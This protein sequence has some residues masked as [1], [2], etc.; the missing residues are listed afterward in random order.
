MGVITMRMI[1]S[2]S[3]T[4][5]SGVTLIAELTGATLTLCTH[6]LVLLQEEVEKFGRGVRHLDLEPLEPRR[7]IVERHD[8][9]NGDQDAERGRD[10]RLGDTGRHGRETARSRRRDAGERVDDPDDRAEQADE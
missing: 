5:T 4:S 8:R 9:G 10:E 1:K 6:R 2:T 7:E 3:M